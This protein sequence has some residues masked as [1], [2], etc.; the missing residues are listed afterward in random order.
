MKIGTDLR[1]TVEQRLQEGMKSPVKSDKFESV[2]QSQ[3]K[4]LQTDHLSTLFNKI[5]D[6]GKRLLKSQTLSDLREYKRLVKRFMKETVE[7]GMNLKKSK[8]W[9]GN[10]HLETMRLV[11]QIDGELIALTDEMVTR[12]GKSIDI[13]GRI[14][15]I[16]GLLV[17]LYT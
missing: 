2:V 7:F 10:G 3:Q 9:S 16:K 1:T 6:Q 4:K 14:G 17:N 11:E 15:E 5:D 12:E 8:S 13:L